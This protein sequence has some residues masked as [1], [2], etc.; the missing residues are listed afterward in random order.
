MRKTMK[1]WISV[2]LAAALA[3]SLFA[4]APV[5]VFA[6]DGELEYTY[7]VVGGEPEIFGTGWDADNEDNIMTAAEDGTYFKTYTVDKAYKDV[8]I[9]VVRTL[10]ADS[11]WF[12]DATGNNLTFNLTAAGDFTVTFAPDTE[13]LGVTGEI[14][15]FVTEFKY[16]TVYAVGNG[17]G[18][19]L[20][21]ASWDPGFAAN[22]MHEVSKDV[23]ETEYAN[24]A[25]G[26]ERQVKFSID[27]TWTHNFGG[28]FDEEL[29][30]QPQEAVYNGDNITFDTYDD[31][32]TIKL[33]L[34]LREFDFATKTG[35]KYTLT[36]ISDDEPEPTTDPQPTT[37]PEPT[38][39]SA[40]TALKVTAK[41]NYFPET[42]K[43]YYDLSAL[44]DKNGDVYITVEYKLFAAN[45]HVINL[46]VDEL[47]Y[48]PNVLEWSEEYNKASSGVVNLFP[49]AAEEGFGPGTI[50]KTA[51]GRIV[52]N[53]SSVKPAAFAYTE[54]GSAT[55]IVKAVFKLIDRNAAETVIN[56]NVDTLSLCDETA[57]PYPQYITIEGKKINAENYALA[58]YS[59]V[60]IPD[61]QTPQPT[62]LAGDVNGDGVVNIQDATLLQRYLA[63]FT[64]EDGKPLLDLNNKQTFF[65][66]DANGDGK[67]NV[68]DVTAIQRKAAEF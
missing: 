24:V 21:G 46:D 16:D 66:A 7:V 8:Q 39:P 25:D 56:C 37:E 15:E 55:T 5:A 38:T 65:R 48:D 29:D 41:S 45:K 10:G 2:L 49:F 31:S 42:S 51:N 54:D 35:A 1:K 47:T 44:E 67:V 30:G 68:R 62:V 32:Q 40:D 33:Q 23:W 60:I 57:S 18:W 43:N 11:D 13:T 22:E 63:E 27:G 52:G 61:S 26:F 14:V 64:T 17:E 6:D 58:Q 4:I 19:W 59:T 53:Y 50:H 28:S 20:N 3:A 36:I 9:K 34:D 12:G